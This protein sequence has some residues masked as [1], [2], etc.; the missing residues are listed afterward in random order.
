MDSSDDAVDPELRQA[1]LSRFGRVLAFMTLAFVALVVFTSVKVGRYAL[2]AVGYWLLTGTHVFN[3]MSVVEVCA[4]HLH[5]TPEPPSIRLRAPVPADL[6]TVILAC[7]AKLPKD[8]PASAH[9][10]REQLAACA[11]A[12]AWTNERA[13]AWWADHRAQLRSGGAA[14]KAPSTGGDIRSPNLTVTRITD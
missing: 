13:A 9:V 3:G 1:R 12:N 6:E 11:A 2:G 8:R 7:L 14:A 4:H 5:S 10:L